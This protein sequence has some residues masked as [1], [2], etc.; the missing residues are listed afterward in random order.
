V[1]R[2][3]KVTAIDVLT[4]QAAAIQSFIEEAT[5]AL[6]YLDHQ[7][8]RAQQWIGYDRKEY[9]KNEV[10]DGWDRV[11]RARAE[12]ER[13][14]TFRKAGDHQPACID[15]KKALQ[16]VQRRLQ[17]AQDRV[18]AVRRWEHVIDR[19]VL[20]LTG[21]FAQLSDWIQGELPKALAALER[22]T[23]ALETYVAMETPADAETG[24][25]R[26]AARAGEAAASADRAAEEEESE[27]EPEGE[28]ADAS[29]DSPSAG[30]DDH[31]VMG[32][33]HTGSSTE[34]GDEGP[35]SGQG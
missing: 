29:D 9:W 18:R 27:K 14:L 19:H 1:N 25:K 34:T 21:S 10:R 11:A 3:A 23:D 5:S 8:K 22:M 35:P 24:R 15:E 4:A 16:R 32:S 30:S 12:L 7:V 33:D 26:S 31:E 20:D 2:F 17:I 13:C 28:S 6:D